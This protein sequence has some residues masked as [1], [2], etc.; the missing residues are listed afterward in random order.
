MN[1]SNKEVL[2]AASTELTTPANSTQNATIAMAAVA[3]HTVG[4][5]SVPTQTNTAPTMASDACACSRSRIG[6]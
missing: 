3:S 2:A 1:A 4:D 5:A 6:P